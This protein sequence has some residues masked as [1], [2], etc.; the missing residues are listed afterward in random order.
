MSLLAID[1]FSVSYSYPA[2]KRV[3]NNVCLHIN[4]GEI[5]A[6]VGESGAGKTTLGLSIPGL[7]DNSGGVNINGH[8][9]FDDIDIYQSSAPVVAGL[10]GKRIGYIFQEPLLALNPVIQAGELLR[11][12]IH[13][14][15]KLANSKAEALQWLEK[16]GLVSAKRY[17]HY[18]PHQL[19][20]GMRQRVMLALA[21][22][23]NPDLVI[24]DEPTSGV[25]ATMKHEVME[26]LVAHCRTG[27]S[28]LI[29]THDI[30]IAAQYSQK[31]FVMYK[32]EVVESGPTKELVKQPTHPYTRVLLNKYI[33]FM[34]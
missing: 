10:R 22:A 29:I 4:T 32:G 34:N 17:Y 24:A 23:G 7:L 33:H 5:C 26:L 9:L 1:D 11:E 18:Y 15:N 2:P 13:V 21:L 28:L 27:K 20:G 16:L 3:V 25:D 8:I 12:T 14:H 30:G 6:L 31:L 19:S